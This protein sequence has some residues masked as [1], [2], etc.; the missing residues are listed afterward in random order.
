MRSSVA[1]QRGSSNVEYVPSASFNN[2]TAGNPLTHSASAST[3]D[4]SALRRSYHE[5]QSSDSK[6]SL[7]HSL[8]RASGSAT[9]PSGTHPRKTGPSGSSS[10]GD[11]SSFSFASS[12]TA[13]EW[14][15]PSSATTE[16]D[17]LTS[18]TSSPTPASS[19]SGSGHASSDTTGP[20][21][22]RL[23]R[24]PTAVRIS[25]SLHPL[26]TST[27][28]SASGP[29][30]ANDT[31]AGPSD[32]PPTQPQTPSASRTNSPSSGRT[33]AAPSV[34]A[35]P[36]IED[37]RSLQ[38]PPQPPA[39][40]KA[41]PSYNESNPSS[42]YSPLFDLPV[43]AQPKRRSRAQTFSLASG[44]GSA[45]LQD[46]A[47]QREQQQNSALHLDF[48]PM[49]AEPS[50]GPQ[51]AT[52]T[53]LSPATASK[54]RHHRLSAQPVTGV[55]APTED[56]YARIIMQSRTA[57][58][59]KWKGGPDTEEKPPLLRPDAL[60]RRA[61]LLSSTRSTGTRDPSSSVSS[62]RWSSEDVAPADEAD[63]ADQSRQPPSAYANF[64]TATSIQLDTAG[65]DTPSGH[66]I[67]WVDWLEEYR[68]MKE[69]KVLSERRSYAE[70]EPATEDNQDCSREFLKRR[71]IEFV[72]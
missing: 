8:V 3:A 27:P 62:V 50:T 23:Q 5:K 38:P 65:A 71:M 72:D 12:S 25:Q 37:K 53:S 43:H 42:A 30:P 29:G 10:I 16:Q 59:K 31:R 9:P 33:S 39:S 49:R 63:I 24:V 64:S 52:S 58:V 60:D 46:A 17:H 56:E 13:S 61:S 2:Q 41:D 45:G 70:L 57:K 36:R 1:S 54:R 66:N 51:P 22:I 48:G 47:N 7:E 35:S 11:L 67:E 44:S 18:E 21:P 68:R 20:E 19:G 32:S 26:L 15:S 14:N 34:S 6:R 55:G 69:A 28:L 4:A 40:P